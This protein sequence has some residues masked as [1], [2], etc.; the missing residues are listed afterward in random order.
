MVDVAD[1]VDRIVEQWARERPE[2]ETEAMAAFGRV[3]RLAKIVGDR[4]ERVY[5][6]LGLNRGEFDVLATLRRSGEPF[7]LSPK[8]LT[9]SLML[10]SG[11][12]TGRLDRLE[13]AG[14]V[15][16]SPDPADRRGLVVT[17]TGAGR[18]LVDEAVA[19]GLAEQRE[20]FERLPEARRRQLSALL[21]EL[22]SA[23]E[24]G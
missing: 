23:A 3:Y 8:A 10:T 14:L 6:A 19:V 13:R 20:V 18:V 17:L 4:Q 16:R 9:S 7:Q 5:G 2:L 15:A 22:L 21:R 12:M 1:D 11:G 24:E